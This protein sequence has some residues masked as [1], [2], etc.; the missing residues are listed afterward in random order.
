M[1]RSRIDLSDL[2]AQTT[3]T[4]RSPNVGVRSQRMLLIGLTIAVLAVTSIFVRVR[5]GHARMA[6]PNDDA[7]ALP[8]ICLACQS[9]F[10]LTARAIVAAQE[11]SDARRTSDGDG[12]LAFKCPDCDEHAAVRD[13]SIQTAHLRRRQRQ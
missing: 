13:A 2:D 11:S 7:S 3:T 9:Q 1:A 8:F 4:T 10:R 6:I 12:A 5:S